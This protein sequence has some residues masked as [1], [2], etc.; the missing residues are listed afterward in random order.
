MDITGSSGNPEAD[1]AHIKA[2]WG[3]NELKCNSRCNGENVG[4]TR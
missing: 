4:E 2:D 1:K 3:L